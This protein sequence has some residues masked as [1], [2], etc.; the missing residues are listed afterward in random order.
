MAVPPMMV[1]VVYA[2]V[3]IYIYTHTYIIVHMYIYICI[4]I[5]VCIYIY[6]YIYTYIYIY[7]YMYTRT[8]M[9]IYI[10][11]YIIYIYIY[12]F[13]SRARRQGSPVFCAGSRCGA[14]PG[15]RSGL[16]RIHRLRI[17]EDKVLGGSPLDLE[18][19]EGDH[20]AGEGVLAAR[21]RLHLRGRERDS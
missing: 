2:Y 16:P 13:G 11:I 9:C 20:P 19:A 17:S 7:I 21:G 14:L 8:H 1:E 15:S 6:I 18:E 4:Y 3:Y 10:Y 5:H 12:I